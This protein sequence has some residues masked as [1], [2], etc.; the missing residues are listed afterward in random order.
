RILDNIPRLEGVLDILSTYTQPFG[1]PGK[2]R[3]LPLGSRI[4]R[5]ALD[6]DELEGRGTD[7][8]VVLA[9]M[10]G[11]ERVYDPDLLQRFGRIVAGETGIENS[12]VAQISLLG[13]RAGM[14]LADDV[15]ASNG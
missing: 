1:G 10:R 12:K 11:R 14:F 8:G 3:P 15:R 4:L 5:I 13:L 6:Y 7:E 2:G 9:V